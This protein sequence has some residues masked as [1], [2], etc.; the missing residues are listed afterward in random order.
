VSGAAAARAA[1]GATALLA[2]VVA[3]T[4]VLPWA[5][6]RDPALSVLRARSAEREP[7][8]AALEAVR[9]ELGL[10]DGPLPALTAWVGGLARGDLGTSWVTREPVAATLGSA[11]G[12]SLTLALASTLVCVLV[13][14]VLCLPVVA[15]PDRR[16]GRFGRPG[17]R[18]PGDGLVA[19]ALAAVPE[20]LLAAMLVVVAAAR[21][22]WPRVGG[23]AGPEDV[24]LPALALGIPAGGVFGLVMRGA[25]AAALTEPWVRTWTAAGLRPALLRRAA[26]RRAVAVSG[27]LLG[28]SVGGLLG[29][30]VAVETVFTVPGVGRLGLGAVLAGDLPVVQACL[31]AIV[32]GGFLVAA[33]GRAL[34]RALV[35]AGGADLP[36]PPPAGH[37]A[38]GPAAV[39]SAVVLLGAVAAGALR[40]PGATS[41]SQ[42]LEGPTWA[43]PLGTDALGRDVLARLAHGAAP[44]VGTALLVTAAALAVGL[45]A[46]YLLRGTGRLG[47]AGNAVPAVT[48]GLLVAAVTG[49]GPWAAVVAVACV[50][51]IPLAAHAGALFSEQRRTGYCLACEAMGGS[52]WGVLRRHLL[53]GVLGPVGV[54]A[55]ARVPQAALGLAGLAFLG[56]GERPPSPQWGRLLAEGLPYVDRAPWTV[57]APAGALVAVGLV[58][59]AVPGWLRMLGGVRHRGRTGARRTSP[60]GVTQGDQ[61]NSSGRGGPRA[62]GMLARASRGE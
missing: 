59:A 37:T 18:E 20:F 21:P 15:R 50:A 17:R 52:R 9:A 28:L 6:G 40:D 31:L 3:A 16:F 36:A 14:V 61:V 30:A 57:L 12:V 58:A 5:S 47:D 22:G 11:L 25:C 29:G 38:G 4:A 32:G 1:A 35:G 27:P 33:A 54:H 48:A 2:A 13:A 41:L 23:W 55:A 39:A 62:G 7:D 46:G 49:P 53:P 10:P 26:L 19:P 45:L 24:V 8:T 42:R 56:L 44:T 34:H 43:Y 60:G 51:W